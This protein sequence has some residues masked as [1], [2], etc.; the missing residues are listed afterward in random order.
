M[1]KQ[2]YPPFEER[3]TDELIVLANSTELFW[4]PEAVEQAKVELQRRMISVEEQHEKLK[5]WA[6]EFEELEKGLEKAFSDKRNSQ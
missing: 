1:E 3:D 4:Q 5:K 6:E 2:F